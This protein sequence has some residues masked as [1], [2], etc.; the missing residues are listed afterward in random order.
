MSPELLNRNS[1]HF[2]SSVLLFFFFFCDAEK[3]LES[4]S[5][6]KCIR[7]FL[8]VFSSSSLNLH[9]FTFLWKLISY[10]F[11]GTEKVIIDPSEPDQTFFFL[12][13]LKCTEEQHIT[14]SRCSSKCTSGRRTD[15]TSSTAVFLQIHQA[16]CDISWLTAESCFFTAGAERPRG[17]LKRFSQHLCF[18]LFSVAQDIKSHSSKQDMREVYSSFM[19][20]IVQIRSFN[21]KTT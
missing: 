11:K 12:S 2:L 10:I 16:F 8:S 6:E 20:R 19:W 21:L 4:S 17:R 1:P 18:V 15:R 5:N 9:F 14:V 13:F 7:L 3:R